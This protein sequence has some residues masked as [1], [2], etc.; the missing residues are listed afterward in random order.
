MSSLLHP[1]KEKS[2]W[3]DVFRPFRSIYYGTQTAASHTK[4][5]EKEFAGNRFWNLF[6]ATR[7][8]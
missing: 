1:E 5:K 3:A 8:I 7:A 2:V 6:L 4:R